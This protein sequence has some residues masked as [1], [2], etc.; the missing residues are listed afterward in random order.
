MTIVPAHSESMAHAAGRPEAHD[1]QAAADADGAA[2]ERLLFFGEDGLQFSDLLDVLNPLQ[3]I[4]LIGS[5]YRSTTADEISAGARMAGGTLY[6]GPLGFLGA[7]ANTMVEDTTGVDIGGNLAALMSGGEEA[8][9]DT[10][11]TPPAVSMAAAAPQYETWSADNI[12]AAT[13]SDIAPAAG[14][15]AS[16]LQHRASLPAPAFPELRPTRVAA[17]QPRI[18]ASDPGSAALSPSAFQTLLQRT[19]L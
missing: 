16:Y 17:T 4:P 12:I 14:P 11:S 13:L 7:L 2:A 15:P 19:S 9:A 18:A 6:G 3:H 8:N 5:I 10:N 1:I